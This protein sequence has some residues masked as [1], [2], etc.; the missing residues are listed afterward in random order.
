MEYVRVE[1]PEL[2]KWM[3]DEFEDDLI[4]AWDNEVT[5]GFVPEELYNRV[6]GETK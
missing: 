4:L 6:K 3:T 1:W 2:Q 5:I